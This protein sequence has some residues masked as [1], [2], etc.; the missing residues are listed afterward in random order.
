MPEQTEYIVG[1]YYLYYLR[2]I[3]LAAILINE[4]SCFELK[5]YLN[6]SQN[7]QKSVQPAIEV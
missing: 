2:Y 1:I 3:T 6:L 4:Y 5:A 7:I